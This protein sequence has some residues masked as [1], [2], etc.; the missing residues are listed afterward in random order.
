V[1]TGRCCCAYCSA[2]CA[3]PVL[4]LMLYAHLALLLLLLL[5][6]LLYG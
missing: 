2:H 3:H 4:L 5:L 1:R 6:L